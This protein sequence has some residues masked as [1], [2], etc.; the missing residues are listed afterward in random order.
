MLVI[1][2]TTLTLNHDTLPQQYP[3]TFTL[4]TREPVIKIRFAVTRRM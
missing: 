3:R 1:L 2:L 4:P